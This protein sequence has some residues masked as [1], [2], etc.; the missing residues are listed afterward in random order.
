MPALL[1]RPAHPDYDGSDDAVLRC[2]VAYNRHGGYCVP[3]RAMHR[4]CAQAILRG[5]EFEPQTVAAI[6]R[7]AQRGDIVHA[8]AFFGDMLPA[9]SRAAGPGTV[10]WA[11]EP[12]RESHRCA[13]LTVAINKLANVRLAPAALGAS[14]GEALLRV[15]DRVGVALGGKSAIVEAL[16]ASTAGYGYLVP[17]ARIDDTVPADRKVA[18]IHLDLEQREREALEGALATIHRCLPAL[19]LETVP[20][21]GW[22]ATHL[23]PLG[24]QTAGRVGPNTL[25]CTGGPSV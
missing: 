9:A 21:A 5:E 11:Y 14:P 3:R 2:V 25:L 19:I 17:V 7:H 12:N 10:V 4:P 1:D 15:A 16:D 8:G 23:V 6:C 13:A 22:C 24:Y 18:L 20:D